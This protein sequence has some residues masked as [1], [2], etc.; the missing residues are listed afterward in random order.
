M[1][2]LLIPEVN[3]AYRLP[4]SIYHRNNSKLDITHGDSFRWRSFTTK[5]SKGSRRDSWL[6]RPS[7]TN[8]VSRQSTHWSI[9]PIVCSVRFNVQHYLISGFPTQLMVWPDMRVKLFRTYSIVQ[10]IE[11]KLHRWDTF[12]ILNCIKIIFTKFI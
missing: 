1:Q 2:K 7:Q 11:E 4:N 8:K 3:K 12:S 6:A 10:E 5:R 9:V